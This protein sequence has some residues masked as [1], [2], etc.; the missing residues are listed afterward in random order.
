M[1]CAASSSTCATKNVITSSTPRRFAMRLNDIGLENPVVAEQNHDTSMEAVRHGLLRALARI[2]LRPCRGSDR[3]DAARRLH[4]RG[5]SRTQESGGRGMQVGQ[6][7]VRRKGRLRH[8]LEE[9]APAKC[10]PSRLGNT[11]P[12]DVSAVATRSIAKR[13]RTTRRAQTGAAASSPTSAVRPPRVSARNSRFAGGRLPIG[14]GTPAHR[15]VRR[16]RS[17][18]PVWMRGPNPRSG[19]PLPT[20]MKGAP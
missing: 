5:A 8:A 10:M 15:G 7:A 13:L 9:P 19:A 2:L 6:H 1:Q 16:E 17:G 12:I 3:H 4:H 18:A 14:G 11:S 20:R